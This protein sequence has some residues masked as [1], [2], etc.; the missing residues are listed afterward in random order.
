MNFDY[1][2]SIPS[3]TE[4]EINYVLSALSKGEVAQG[5]ALLEFENHL[6][7][8]HQNFECAAVSSGTAALHLALKVLGV[9]E[10]DFVLV[11]NHTFAATLFAVKYVGAIPVIVDFQIEDLT[12]DLLLLEEAILSCISRGKKPRA[13]ISVDLYGY[14]SDYEEIYKVTKKYGIPI[15]EDAAEGLGSVY[16]GKPVGTLGDISILS[17]NANKVV[18]TGGGGA[19]LSSNAKWIEEV[20][21][22]ANQ[23]KRG[24]PHFI[25]ETIG[26]NYRL[27]NM[28]AALGV[29]QLQ[30]LPMIL[31]KKKI[32]HE[33]YLEKLSGNGF[34]IFNGTNNKVLSNNWLSLLSH[35]EMASFQAKLIAILKEESIETRP[36]WRPMA[37][38]PAFANCPSFVS[39]STKHWYYNILA[40]PSSVTLE[41][42]DLEFIV[43]KMK[44]TLR[45]IV[46]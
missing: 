15:L 21:F 11:P 30:R 31:Q 37:M 10:N 45:I 25:H 5:E 39:E 40:L 6:S 13:L 42:G 32:I 20:K 33:F 24:Y 3:I 7:Q 28:A 16:R 44:E 1:P 36:G 19:V 43:K 4:L 14:S 18:T 27:S 46:A 29:A 2:L 41:I 26:Y 38:Q 23:A 12:Y 17:F 35:P 9:R 34:E 22:L 8:I